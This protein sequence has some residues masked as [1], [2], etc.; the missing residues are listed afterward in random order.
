MECRIELSPLREKKTY[1]NNT[2]SWHSPSWSHNL[3]KH[4][5]ADGALCVGSLGPGELAAIWLYPPGLTEANFIQSVLWQ[6][7]ARL[8]QTSLS[9]F[10]QKSELLYANGYKWCLHVKLLAK[11]TGTQ[12]TTTFQVAWLIISSSSCN[13]LP[14]LPR[15]RFQFWNQMIAR[16]MKPQMVQKQDHKQRSFGISQLFICSPPGRGE[17]EQAS[18]HLPSPHDKL[19]S[20]AAACPPGLP[21]PTTAGAQG[22]PAPP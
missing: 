13:P 6:E 5:T 8:T 10:S 17:E 2:A 1:W 12:N 7:W 21:L 9:P 11:D 19:G 3:Y 16:L 15:S 20:P 18:A 14:A 4:K 22:G